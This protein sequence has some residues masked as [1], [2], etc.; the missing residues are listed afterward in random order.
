MPDN[1]RTRLYRVSGHAVSG[2]NWRHTRFAEDVPQAHV[3]GLCGT[4]PA[5]TVLLPCSHLLCE[6]CRGRKHRLV[7]SP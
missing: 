2:V 3:C 5:S 4:I 6:P 1:R 7:V